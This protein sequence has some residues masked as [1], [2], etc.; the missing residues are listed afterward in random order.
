MISVDYYQKYLIDQREAEKT[1]VNW[2]TVNSG[3][4]TGEYPFQER[5]AAVLPDARNIKNYIEETFGNKKG[6]T[7]GLELGGIGSQLFSEFSPGFFHKTFGVTLIDNRYLYPRLVENTNHEVI[8]GDVFS[9]ATV[10]NVK[11]QLPLKQADVIF[12]GMVGALV[13][14][15]SRFD[16]FAGSASRWYKLLADGG[17]AF[18]ELPTELIPV[19]PEWASRIKKDFGE[20]LDVDYDLDYEVMRLQKLHGAPSDLPLLGLEEIIKI[21][22][23][24]YDFELLFEM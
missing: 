14:L 2:G 4:L 9:E 23:P 17:L 21:H 5:F 7:V 22:R 1:D 13:C 8:E 19:L 3:L 10:E 24:R 15:P 6:Q 11:T 12:E 20:T 18:L 16:F